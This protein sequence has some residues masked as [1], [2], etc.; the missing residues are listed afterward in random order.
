MGVRILPN[1]IPAPYGANGRIQYS[2]TMGALQPPQ[3]IPK[4]L[5]YTSNPAGEMPSFGYETKDD[6]L[7]YLSM[8]PPPLPEEM[9]LESSYDLSQT[10]TPTTLLPPLTANKPNPL[11]Q[12]AQGVG[13]LLLTDAIRHAVTGGPTETATVAPNATIEG[14]AA[15]S[16]GLNYTPVTP[17]AYYDP[18]ISHPTGVATSTNGSTI[19]SDGTTTAGEPYPVA[20]SADGGTI[21]SDGSVVPQQPNTPILGPAVGMYV[22]ARGTQQ[23]LRDI[24]NGYRVEG[25]QQLESPGSAWMADNA[26]GVI[27]QEMNAQDRGTVG[28][29]TGTAYGGTPYSGLLG[30]YDLSQ[31]FSSGGSR[32]GVG[33]QMGRAASSSAAAATVAAPFTAGLS[34][35]IMAGYGAIAGGINAVTGSGKGRGQNWRDSWRD[36]LQ[37]PFKGEGG[38]TEAPAFLDPDFKVR[39]SSGAEWDWGVDRGSAK[40]GANRGWEIDE[41]DPRTADAIAMVEPLGQIIT[42]GDPEQNQYATGYLV[43]TILS[44]GDPME[45]ARE[46]YDRAGIDYEKARQIIERNQGISKDDKNA[47]YN[48]LDRLYGVNAYQGKTPIT[49]DPTRRAGGLSV[50]PVKQ[51]GVAMNIQDIQRRTEEARAGYK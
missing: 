31:Q 32:Q 12:G 19:M 14:T 48:S 46:L 30:A 4:S 34:W 1:N 29:A 24:Q 15:A 45:N 3:E 28:Q 6:T 33:R 11:L 5:S 44:A 40:P 9:P 41:S 13:S 42:G 39:L 8:I 10:D 35:P 51:R 23:A 27:G 16:E 50:F 38:L 2:P 47:Y 22:G 21:M 18:S 49:G 26:L 7:S 43:N 25:A 36:F 20:T 17:P 37:K